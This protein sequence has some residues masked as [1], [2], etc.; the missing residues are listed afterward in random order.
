MPWQRGNIFVWDAT[1]SYILAPSH[2]DIAVR[3]PREVAAAAKH[4]KRAKYSHLEATHH[5][6]PLAVESLGVLGHEARAFL[7][8]LMRRLTSATDD[9]QS[10][11]FLLQRV[12]VAIQGGNAAAVLGMIGVRVTN[13]LLFDTKC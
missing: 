1:C 7:R 2:R 6:V 11:Q 12:A 8:D 5:F 10:H 13:N 4:R 3:Q 9:Q